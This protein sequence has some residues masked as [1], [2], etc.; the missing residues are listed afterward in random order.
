[1]VIAALLVVAAAQIGDVNIDS[2]EA[3]DAQPLL[4]GPIE[5]IEEGPRE[6]RQ[7]LAAAL[8]GA[9]VGRRFPIGYG[10]GYGYPYYAGGY[11]G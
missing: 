7:L 1:M 4:A 9:A 5:T 3:D 8:L 2:A 6:K 10:Y 11:Y